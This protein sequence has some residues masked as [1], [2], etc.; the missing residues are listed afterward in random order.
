[1]V[2]FMFNRD[3]CNYRGHIAELQIQMKS[4]TYEPTYNYIYNRWQLAP[5][6]ETWC[7]SCINKMKLCDT[8]QN[9]SRAQKSKQSRK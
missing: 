5:P 8:H 9:N 7:F 1:M 3:G 6:S 2:V 4:V